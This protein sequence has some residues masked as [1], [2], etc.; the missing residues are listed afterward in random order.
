MVEDVYY[1]FPQ[2]PEQSRRA[3]ARG[4]K[5]TARNRRER[6]QRGAAQA[7]DLELRP[8][9]HVQKETTA[10]A[11]ALLDGKYPWLCGAERSRSGRIRDLTIAPLG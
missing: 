3:G 1:Q 6:L 8:R 7:L 10:A 4:G 5:A 9:A 2:K 11:M